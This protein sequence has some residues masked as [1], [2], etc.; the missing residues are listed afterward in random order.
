MLQNIKEYEW[1][2]AEVSH[3]LFKNYSNPGKALLDLCKLKAKE[4]FK[5]S[6]FDN[7]DDEDNSIKDNEHWAEFLKSKNIM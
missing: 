2:P 6:H 1:T 5:F 7:A 4:V 3:I